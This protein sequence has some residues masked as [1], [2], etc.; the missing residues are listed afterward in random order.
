MTAARQAAG[1]LG[2]VVIDVGTVVRYAEAEYEVADVQADLLVL[3]GRAE[4]V[5]R[6]SRERCTVLA[7]DVQL[8]GKQTRMEGA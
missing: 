8:V 3:D 4:L 2:G 7:S 6:N 5:S 1:A